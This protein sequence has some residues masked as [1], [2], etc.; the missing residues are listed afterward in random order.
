MEV[1]M[2]AAFRAF[3]KTSISLAAGLLF[4]A[5]F[6]HETFI[7]VIKMANV[8]IEVIFM[9]FCLVF[10]QLSAKLLQAHSENWCV[11]L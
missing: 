6:P 1:P 8:V 9:E 4:I 7:S 11:V 5:F 2:S 3:S 10:L